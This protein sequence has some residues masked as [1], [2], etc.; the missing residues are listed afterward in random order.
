MTILKALES[1]PMLPTPLMNRINSSYQNLK[2]DLIP[3]LIESG[4]V[5]KKDHGYYLTQKGFECLD[6]LERGLEMIRPL[7]VPYER[8]NDRNWFPRQ[9]TTDR[10][11]HA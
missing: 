3:E 1:G 6:L 9:R 8:Q 5:G 2:V 11:K 4:L 10:F 7:R